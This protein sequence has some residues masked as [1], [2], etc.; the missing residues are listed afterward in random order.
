MIIGI[1]YDK[2]DIL[3]FLEQDDVEVVYTCGGAKK[4]WCEQFTEFQNVDV[5]IDDRPETVLFNS[6]MTIDELAEW[7]AEN[8]AAA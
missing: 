2:T 4:W 3:L 1:D 5:W 8:A 6:P 7:R